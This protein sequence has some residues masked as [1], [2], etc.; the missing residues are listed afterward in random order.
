MSGSRLAKYVLITPQSEAFT[1]LFF[2]RFNQLGSCTSLLDA[3]MSILKTHS[4][5][6]SKANFLF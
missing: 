6:H 5:A 3:F 1:V 4:Y 2:L